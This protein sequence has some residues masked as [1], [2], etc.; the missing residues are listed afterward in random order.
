MSLRRMPRK[1]HKCN[2]FTGKKLRHLR[3]ILRNDMSN[4]MSKAEFVTLVSL[5]VPS[6]LSTFLPAPE[7]PVHGG[8]VQADAVLANHL[9]NK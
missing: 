5:S 4:Y 8:E 1:C 3:G 6:G 7:Q 9:E 2:K